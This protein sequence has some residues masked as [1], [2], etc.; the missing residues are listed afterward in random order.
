M[1]RTS[2]F[3][4]QTLIIKKRYKMKKDS[5]ILRLI[6][7]FA[8]MVALV[9]PLVMIQALINERQSYRN[10]AVQEICKSWATEQIVAGPILTVE[11]ASV[12]S[13]KGSE[14][15]STKSITQYLPENLEIDCELVP[16]VR[17]RGIFEVVV[18][19]SKIKLIGNFTGVKNVEEVSG[20]L[21]SVEKFISF[22]ISDL[23]GIDENVKLKINNTELTVMPG[24]KN[25]GTFRNGF[26]S[27]IDFIDSEKLFFSAEI[28]LKGSSSIQFIPLGKTSEVRINSKWDNPSFVGSYLPNQREISESGFSSYWKINHFNREYPQVWHDKNYEIFKSSFGAKLLMPVDEYQKTMRTS[29]YGIMI[30]ILTFVSFFMIEIFSNRVI[31]PVQ[32]LLVGLS[33][34]IF[35]STLLSISEYIV[36]KYSYLISSILVITL[37]ALYVKSIYSSLKITMIITSML[38][39]FYG[40]NYIILQ[41]Q[42]YA[43]LLG[44]ISLFIILAVIMYLTRKLNWFE[45]LSNNNKANIS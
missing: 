2:A 32:Y 4:L 5:I 44:N 17:Y 9:I 26:S 35:Y 25:S 18:Y 31:H 28:N 16:E 19:K 21:S 30:I 34:L 23:R 8:I 43:L 29:K 12:N 33:L 1:N 6:L 38:A 7:I 41:L 27:S 14:N 20:N 45:V 15:V 10:E 40:L 24:L 36:F 11:T 13:V 22:N 37:I 3:I 39:L 42:D